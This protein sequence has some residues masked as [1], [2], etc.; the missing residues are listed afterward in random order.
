MQS[1][2]NKILRD[3]III[4]FLFAAFAMLVFLFSG[5]LKPKP[6]TGQTQKQITVAVE[7]V[8][9]ELLE[10]VKIEERV[11]DRT[12][13]AILGRIAA[14]SVEPHTYERAVNGESIIVSKE[15]YCDAYFVIRLDSSPSR[16]R[17]SYYIGEGISISTPSFS[18]EGRVCSIGAESKE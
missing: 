12:Q 1:K 7:D 2:K 13:R 17:G 3:L 8:P 16:D 14:L 15:G 10:E 5:I 4:L 11:L 6:G 9:Y 18:G